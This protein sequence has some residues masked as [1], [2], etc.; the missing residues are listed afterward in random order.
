MSLTDNQI[1]RVQSSFD[2]LR[3]TQLLPTTDF[4]ETL[5]WH[6]PE[7]RSLFRDDL[8]GQGMKFMS[9][10]AV[11]VDDLHDPEK[12]HARFTE[13]GRAHAALGITSKHF[14]PMEDALMETLRGRL[15]D[16]FDADT[17]AAWRAAYGEV[18][19]SI[20]EKGGIA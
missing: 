20:V 7:Y 10:L 1:A 8:E 2:M 3:D 6:A 16:V 18:A 5:F 4:Y 12:L 9:T 14:L 19:R 13:L 11:I 17:E 15:G